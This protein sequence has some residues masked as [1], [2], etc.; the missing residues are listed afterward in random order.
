VLFGPKALGS[1]PATG[2]SL[3]GPAG[4]MGPSSTRSIAVDINNKSVP[5]GFHQLLGSYTLTNSEGI[6]AKVGS[7]TNVAMKMPGEQVPR[8]VIVI[9]GG[10]GQLFFPTTKCTGNVGYV[11]GSSL[12]HNDSNGLATLDDQASVNTDVTLSFWRFDM[13]T[14]PTPDFQPL[15]VRNADGRCA[16]MQPTD[17]PAKLTSALQLVRSEPLTFL[18]A[19]WPVTPWNSVHDG[20]LVSNQ[21]SGNLKDKGPARALESR[22]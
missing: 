20:Q 13:G 19:L 17:P 12:S 14:P 1:W 11:S 15:S 7:F 4:P 10:S 8:Q 9:T 2:V 21:V 22:P 5:F 3:I 16:T 18:N 6:V